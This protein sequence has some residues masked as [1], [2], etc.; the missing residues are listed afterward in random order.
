MTSQG[1]GQPAQRH[2]RCTLGFTAIDPSVLALALATA[3]GTRSDAAPSGSESMLVTDG[4]GDALPVRE[5]DGGGGRTHVVRVDTGPF[6][7]QYEATVAARPVTVDPV[8]EVDEDILVAMRQS[9]Y[10]PSDALEGFARAT[11]PPGPPPGPARATTAR[12]IAAWVHH[13]LSYEAG[14]TGPLD[15]SID[16]LLTHRGV[17]RDFAHLAISLCRALRIPAR[18][19]SVYA[20]GLSPMD[21]HAV[22]EVCTE[23]GWEILDPT[24]MAPRQSLVRIATGRDAADTAFATTISG[25]V[26]LDSAEVAAVVDGDLPVDDH[27]SVVALA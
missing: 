13:R 11:F 8:P 5:I 26:R 12:T 27:L 9:R 15:T 14:S 21:F 3:G 25:D 22:V 1:P 18:L 7:V 24:R 16:T 23:S 10:C 19:V 17:C 20:P 2:V 6:Q 4:A